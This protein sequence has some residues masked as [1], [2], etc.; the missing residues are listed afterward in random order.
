MYILH[1]M[2]ILYI[3]SFEIQMQRTLQH[4]P[5]AAQLTALVYGDILPIN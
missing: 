5:S 4:A 1:Y 2:Y 3:N